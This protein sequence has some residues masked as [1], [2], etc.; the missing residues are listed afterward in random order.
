MK[1]NSTSEL[2]EKWCSSNKLKLNSDKTTEIIFNIS[3]HGSPANTSCR[4]LG[5]Y[6]ESSL[7][8][9]THVNHVSSKL[10][11]GIYMFTMLRASFVYYAHIHS[12]MSYGL[13]FWG[14]NGMADTVFKLQKRAMRTISGDSQRTHC[15]PL[16]TKYRILT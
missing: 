10:S 5:L 8:W 14:N 1:L 2:I 13:L 15:R 11:T 9:L 3:R 6:V 16:F 12:H 7:G 4:F